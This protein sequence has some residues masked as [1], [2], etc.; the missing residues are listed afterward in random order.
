MGDQ[1][2]SM[3]LNNWVEMAEEI[4]LERKIHLG[5]WRTAPFGE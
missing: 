4:L 5:N 1:N 2:F 3:I